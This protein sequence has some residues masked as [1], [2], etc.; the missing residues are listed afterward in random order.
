MASNHL[1][2]PQMKIA[3]VSGGECM[4]SIILWRMCCMSLGTRVLWLAPRAPGCCPHSLCLA[5]SGSAF[6]D[7]TWISGNIEAGLFSTDP[8]GFPGPTLFG[9]CWWV[10]S[11]LLWAPLGLALRSPF[12][13]AMMSCFGSSGSGLSHFEDCPLM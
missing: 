6:Q 4:V 8:G 10:L 13:T 1:P 12:P 2:P 3:F 9:T 11:R 7:K 5:C